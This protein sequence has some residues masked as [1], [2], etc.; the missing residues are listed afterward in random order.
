MSTHR[1]V[2]KALDILLAFTPNNKELGTIDVSKLMGFHQ[3]TVS[4]LLH[5]LADKG[6][7]RQNPGTRKFQLGPAAMHIGLA[8]KKSLQANLVPI[9]KPYME[10]LRE[11]LNETIALEIFSGTNTVLAHLEKGS[12]RINLAGNIGDILEV[13]AAAGAKAILAFS[14]NDVRARILKGTFVRLT[15]NTI[16][17]PKQLQKQFLEIRQQ[18][19]SFEN[20]EHDI[21]TRAMGTPIFNHDGKPIAAL[22]VAGSVQNISL[23]SDSPMAI[24]LKET[25][26]K[27]SQELYHVL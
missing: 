27:I 25:A 7:L 9:A 18:G 17:D 15:P 1:A 24:Q 21:G 20:E 11:D 14:T 8:V 6:F 5:V 4:R 3:S 19:I 16:V 13:H 22:V 23:Q 10:A 2:E 26:A 12:A